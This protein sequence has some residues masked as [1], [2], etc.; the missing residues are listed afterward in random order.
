METFK[1]NQICLHVY[2]L[3]FVIYGLIKLIL[4]PNNDIL[5]DFPT[6]WSTACCAHC[7]R[8]YRASALAKVHQFM[9]KLDRIAGARRGSNNAVDT[10]YVMTDQD[11]TH[12][13]DGII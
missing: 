12:A 3:I 8:G 6:S 4:M 13:V 11:E 1:N 2:G 5:T 9:E 10:V 7:Y